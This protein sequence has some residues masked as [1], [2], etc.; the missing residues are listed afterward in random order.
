MNDFYYEE[1]EHKHLFLKCMLF[2]FII[3]ILGGVS[4]YYKKQH[5]IKLKN[6]TI[7]LGDTLSKDVNDYLIN[8]K[9][10]ANEYKLY[11]DNVDVNTIGKYSYKVKYN[12]H[13]K[14][15]YIN[16]VDKTKP[17]V[18]FNDNVVISSKEDFNINNLMLSCIDKSLPC[19][20]TL[21]NESDYDK[22]K[23]VGE[24][25]INVKVSDSAGNYVTK[26][27]NVTVTD[28]ENVSNTMS[29]DLEYY[30]NSIN[31]DKIDHVLFVKLEKAINEDSL[32]FE[33][34]L[35]ETSS[36]DFSKYVDKSIKD[37]RL[38]TAYNKYGY[39]IGIQVEVSYGDGTKE[40][41]ENKGEINNDEEE[42][43]E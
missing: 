39:V 25:N 11:L 28:D 27:V 16:V 7:E 36:I 40:V 31:D 29:S 17:E 42:K 32:E 33:G 23:N 21:I 18:V 20:V 2:L 26:K 4:I 19:N 37:T 5:T 43:E 15:G 13:T 6:V 14:T 10:Y 38:I 30:T 24:Y 8:G 9:R 35:Q 22:L 3:G 34:M 12:K 1:P 41:I